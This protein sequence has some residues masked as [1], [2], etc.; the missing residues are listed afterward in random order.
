MDYLPVFLDLRERTVVVVGGGEV[1]ARKIGLLRAAG[2]RLRVI[3]PALTPELGSLHSAG[4]IE[5][6]AAEFEASHLSGAA[7]VIAATDNPQINAA[8]HL[9]AT[10]RGLFVNVVDDA[11]HCSFVMPAIIDRSPVLVAV[12][13]AG[14]AP[15]LA[16]HIR[17]LLESV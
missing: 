2:A 5:H 13:T 1:A 15:V 17:A 12:G 11:E 4:H 16:R 14:K 7:L 8:V 9:A 6:L 3:A 10:A